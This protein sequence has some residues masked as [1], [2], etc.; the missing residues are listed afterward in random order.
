VIP[1]VF[2]SLFGGFLIALFAGIFIKRRWL[3]V[4]VSVTWLLLLN[5]LWNL[6][7]NIPIDLSRGFALI[8]I[9]PWVI[10]GMLMAGLISYTLNYLLN[11]FQLTSDN[12]TIYFKDEQDEDTW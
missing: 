9:S 6:L 2:S 4:F 7:S 12:P 3:A 5:I 8:N 11:K 1:F 10:R